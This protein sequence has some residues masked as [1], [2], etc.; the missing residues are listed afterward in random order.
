M[1]TISKAK[2]VQEII[3]EK[4]IPSTSAYRRVKFLKKNGLIKIERIILDD[5]GS[6]Y[7]L[8]RSSISDITVKFQADSIEVGIK[9]NIA[10][11]ERMTNLFFSLRDDE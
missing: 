11:T 10:A 1:A 6:K 5:D 9:R 3:R 7:E 4:N 8:L 2:S